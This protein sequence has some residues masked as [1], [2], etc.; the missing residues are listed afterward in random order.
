MQSGLYHSAV[1]NCQVDHNCCLLQYFLIFGH[2]I[3]CT[4]MTEHYLIDI[5]HQIWIQMIVSSIVIHHLDMILNNV[6][7]QCCQGSLC[8]SVRRNSDGKSSIF[9]SITLC[10]PS[11]LKRCSQQDAQAA[12]LACDWSRLLNVS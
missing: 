12:I 1:S 6:L 8:D 11:A 9:I 3:L 7:W 4:Y 10:L 2:W 5:E